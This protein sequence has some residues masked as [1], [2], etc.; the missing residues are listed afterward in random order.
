VTVAWKCHAKPAALGGKTCGHENI[1]GG[2]G[3]RGLMCCDGCGATKKASD[4][5]LAKLD[6]VAR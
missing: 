5:R 2:M 3:F 6:K 1:T 4:D